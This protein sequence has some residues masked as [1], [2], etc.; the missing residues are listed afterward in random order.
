MFI[1]IPNRIQSIGLFFLCILIT[2]EAISVHANIEQRSQRNFLGSGSRPTTNDVATAKNIK[3]SLQL[4]HNAV[5]HAVPRPTLL[6][7]KSEQRTKASMGVACF[8]VCPSLLIIAAVGAVGIGAGVVA[9][10][11]A[12]TALAD[13]GDI[14][15]S[16]LEVE[17]TRCFEMHELV[18]RVE[19]GQVA[20]NLALQSTDLQHLVEIEEVKEVDQTLARKTWRCEEDGAPMLI[21][22]STDFIL[23]TRE[24]FVN[25]Q[26]EANLPEDQQQEDED[27]AAISEALKGKIQQF[28]RESTSNHLKEK[29]EKKAVVN[30]ALK[31]N[32]CA[33][34]TEGG[35]RVC[36]GN[37]GVDMFDTA[38]DNR[39]CTWCVPVLSDT[40]VVSLFL[41]LF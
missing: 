23:K 30:E 7:E 6:V 21:D 20:F 25:S 36:T 22:E 3:T 13:L 4:Q 14:I 18:F 35:C 41:F 28:H 40:K 15:D 34:F 37:T 11:D 19:M 5:P 1:P 29:E 16:N 27:I 9:Y 12:G 32:K 10:Y 24:E 26:P 2:S 33:M 17:V 38:F 31:E 39:A 8:G